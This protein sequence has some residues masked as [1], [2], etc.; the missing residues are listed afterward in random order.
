MSDRHQY[1]QV[2]AV[3]DVTNSSAQ[4]DLASNP[5][6]ATYLNVERLVISVYKAASGGGGYV[7]VQDTVGNPVFT[8]PA[9]GV[10]VY[11]MDWGDE[12]FQVGPDIGLQAIVAGAATE[13]ASA[14]VAFA[15]HKTFRTA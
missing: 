2:N 6:S 5:G 4:I 10:G 7:R 3:G 8:V 12:G 13:Q 1:Q 11:P 14:S 15:G 9:D